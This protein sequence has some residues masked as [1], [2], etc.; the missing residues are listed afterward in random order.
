MTVRSESWRR[1]LDVVL[2]VPVRSSLIL[3]TTNHGEVTVTGVHGDLELTNVNGPIDA[4]GIRGSV[5]ANSTNGDVVIELLEVTEGKAMAF[6][7]L[8]GDVDVSLP[9]DFK[10]ELRMRSQIGEILTGFDV[11]M[12]ETKTRVER[13]N[14]DGRFRVLMEGETLALING[15]GP[16]MSFRPLNGDILIRRGQRE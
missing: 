3:R 7:T 16:E 5:V 13:D 2:K 10:A 4:R 9:H 12:V 6:S 8:N 15:G 11:E 1:P 14:K